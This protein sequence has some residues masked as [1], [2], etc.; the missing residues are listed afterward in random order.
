MSPDELAQ[1]FAAYLRTSELPDGL[2]APDVF[3]DLNVPQWRFQLQGAEALAQWGKS[4]S[5]HGS[6]V[7]L[8]RVRAAGDTVAVETEITTDGHYSRSL[9]LLRVDGAGL[10]DE[11]VFY[12]TGPW[13]AATVERQAREAPMIRA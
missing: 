8:G 11:V 12:C 3:C 9:W 7:R 6:Q 5:P 2:F 10:V 13:S 4:E 1:R